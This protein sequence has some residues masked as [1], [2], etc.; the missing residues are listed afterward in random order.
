MKIL[1]DKGLCANLPDWRSAVTSFISQCI[2]VVLS[3]VDPGVSGGVVSRLVDPG[4]F[5]RTTD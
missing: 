4:V 2:E 5:T 1:N 3:G